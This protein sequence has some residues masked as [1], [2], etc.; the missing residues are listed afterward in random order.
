[1]LALN[2][3]LVGKPKCFKVEIDEEKDIYFLKKE[4]KEAFSYPRSAIYLDLYLALK[5]VEWLGDEAVENG[6][7]TETIKELTQ[8]DKR[9]CSGH[10]VRTY[11]VGQEEEKKPA[12]APGQVHVLVVAPEYDIASSMP[13]AKKKT[14]TCEDHC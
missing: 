8:K 5:N 10:A 4:V 9:L 13:V 1:M 3:V 11:F 6:E 12:I 7:S 14:P 2:C